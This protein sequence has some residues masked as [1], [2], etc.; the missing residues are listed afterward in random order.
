MTKTLRDVVKEVMHASKHDNHFLMADEIASAV[1]A[2]VRPQIEAE[3]RAKFGEA[4]I[5]DMIATDTAKVFTDEDESI[6]YV[7]ALAALPPTHVCVPV[8]FLYEIAS[9]LRFVAAHDTFNPEHLKSLAD[10][11]TDLLAA[12]KREA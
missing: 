2:H 5:N 1:I 12:S 10:K 7:R 3:A 4:I 11:S 9:A 6:K 8:E